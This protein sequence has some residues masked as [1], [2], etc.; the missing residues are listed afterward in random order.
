MGERGA[1]GKRPTKA[2]EPTYSNETLNAGI[3][4]QEFE[5]GEDTSTNQARRPK[6]VRG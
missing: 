1:R 5:E 6:G 2:P 4:G 3:G